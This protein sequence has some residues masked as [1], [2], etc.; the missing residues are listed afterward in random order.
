MP[1]ALARAVRAVLFD[2]DGTLVDTAPDLGYA[3]NAMRGRR[4]LAPLADAVIRPQASH[5]S[6]GLLGLGFGVTPEH[7]DFPD[8]RQEFLDLY[9]QNLAE[10]S[11]LFPGMAELL[12][13]MEGEGIAWGVVTNKPERFTVPLLRQLGLLERAACV[14]S[15]DTCPQPKPHPGPMLHACRSAGVEPGQCLYVGDAERDVQ[16]ATAA[17]MP[18]VIAL[19]G[20]L[21]AD[22]R[23]EAW[24]A[25][26][27]IDSPTAL[28]D[29]LVQPA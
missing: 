6:Q 26:G 2:L 8:L 5:G 12:A 25:A 28:L 22:D 18:T 7:P 15:G 10:Y 21:G 24:G 14:V 3:L 11:V 13:H 23:P 20:Y 17:G 1:D 16:A 29:Y 19:Y 9:A 4:G 27:Y